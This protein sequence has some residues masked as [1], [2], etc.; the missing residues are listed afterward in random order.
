MLVG[1]QGRMGHGKTLMM[2]ILCEYLHHGLGVQ[3]AANYGLLNAERVKSMSDIWAFN[4]GVMA[5][6]ELWLS[7]DARASHANVFFSQ[8]VNQSRKKKMILFYTTQH[9]RQVDVR[10]R[11]ATDYL[12]FCDKTPQGHWIQIIDWQYREMLRKYLIPFEQA[13]K[14]YPFY[15]TYEV[16]QP[17]ENDGIREAVKPARKLFGVAE[18]SPLRG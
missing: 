10:V 8:L 7:A 6:D 18:K 11:N 13:R 2:T 9:I 17:L 3:L 16:L 1:I 4:S 12:I 14:F 5:I 15:D